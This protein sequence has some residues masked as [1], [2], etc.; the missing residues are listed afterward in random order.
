MEKFIKDYGILI[1][2]GAAVYYFFMMKKEETIEEVVE[3]EDGSSYSRRRKSKAPI[4]SARYLVPSPLSAT[5]GCGSG[6]VELFGRCWC[7]SM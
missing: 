4:R 3:S 1:L 7:G 2:I 5:G 6:C